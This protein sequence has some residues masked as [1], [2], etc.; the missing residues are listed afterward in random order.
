MH[1]PLFDIGQ[2]CLGREGLVAVRRAESAGRP[3]HVLLLA[4]RRTEVH[5]ATATQAG[6]W[7]VTTNCIRDG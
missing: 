6:S 3:L 2:F 4:G 1:V 5:N 7:A